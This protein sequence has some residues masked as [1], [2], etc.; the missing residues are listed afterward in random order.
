[1]LFMMLLMVFPVLGLFLFTVLPLKSALLVY[2]VGT[3]V[4][5]FLHRTMIRT[6]RLRVTSGS[7][8]MVGRRVTV[9]AWNSDEGTVQC[10]SEI[11]SARLEHGGSLRTDSEGVV[12]GL[13]G[14][15]LIL[16]PFSAHD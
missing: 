5:I 12:T 3:A 15:V 7:E 13:R 6:Q 10:G 8:G 11:G 4:S 9:I 2:L 1:M 14:L 16:R